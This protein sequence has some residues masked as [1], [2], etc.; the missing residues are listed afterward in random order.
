MDSTDEVGATVGALLAVFIGNSLGRRKMSLAGSLSMIVGAILQV[1]FTGSGKRMV[2]RDTKLKKSLWQATTYGIPQ[3]IV[4][5]IVSGIGIGLL[6]ATT[7]VF[8]AECTRA[9]DRGN[10]ISV[11]LTCLILGIVIAYWVSVHQ[12]GLRRVRG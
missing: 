6:T 7:P 8:M 12:L 5:R 11:T 10:D 4:G 9:R 2:Y 1:R 3:L